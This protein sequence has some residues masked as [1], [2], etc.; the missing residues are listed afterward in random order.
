MA[1]IVSEVELIV[2]IDAFY[3]G[4]VDGQGCRDS[5]V[6]GSNAH[7]GLDVSVQIGFGIDSVLVAL[8]VEIVARLVQ[9]YLQRQACIRP[10]DIVCV[11]RCLIVSGCECTVNPRLHQ[12]MVALSIG[13]I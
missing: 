5:S 10:Y 1:A 7:G 4:R 6:R 13:I 3:L 9:P 8:Y 11:V 2:F 12:L